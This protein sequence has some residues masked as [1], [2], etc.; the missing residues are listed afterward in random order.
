MPK[1]VE[2]I[3]RVFVE[4]RSMSCFEGKR[5]CERII[6]AIFEYNN[7]RWKDKPLSM[8]LH[9][10]FDITIKRKNLIMLS[11]SDKISLLEMSY[12]GGKKIN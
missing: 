12:E 11:K 3:E 5:S 4:V 7:K 1:A 8:N 6:Y 9:K 2:Y 10:N